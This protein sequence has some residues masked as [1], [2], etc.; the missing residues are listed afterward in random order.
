M[1]F[2]PFVC[3]ALVAAL[4]QTITAAGAEFIVP[5]AEEINRQGMCDRTPLMQAVRRGNAD[6][7]RALLA[8]GAD[9]ISLSGITIPP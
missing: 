4:F 8:A 9:P 1:N 2:R 6:E 3:S 5:A 7:V